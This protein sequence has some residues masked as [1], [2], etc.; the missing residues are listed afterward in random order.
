MVEF[1]NESTFRQAERLVL[2]STNGGIVHQDVC[3]LVPHAAARASCSNRIVARLPHWHAVVAIR[4]KDLG[5]VA[6]GV[7]MGALRCDPEFQ[8]TTPKRGSEARPPQH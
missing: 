2:I 3:P 5:L 6:S 8:E 7:P 1:T 4:A